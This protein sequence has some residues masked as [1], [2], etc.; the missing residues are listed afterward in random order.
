MQVSGYRFR[1]NHALG[2]VMFAIATM[3]CE[4]PAEDDAR[5]DDTS[6]VK[7]V[8]LP[9]VGGC[10]NVGEADP[11]TN[12]LRLTIQGGTP[13][14][15]TDVQGPNVALAPFASAAIAL[16]DGASWVLR[17]ADPMPWISFPGAAPDTIYE[18]FGYWS[19]AD[20]QLEL[21]PRSPSSG[22]GAQDGV[23]VKWDDPT[24]RYLGAVATTSG[25]TFADTR[26]KRLVWNQDNKVPRPITGIESAGAWYITG[27]NA[28]RE[29]NNGASS[30]VQVLVGNHHSSRAY[31]SVQAVGMGIV[32]SPTNGTG[33]IGTGIGINSSSANSA[34]VVEI[35]K[36]TT[37][38]YGNVSAAY[39]G[40]LTY[41]LHSIRWLEIG[42]SGITF[43]VLGTVTSP[44]F[45]KYGLNGY[46]TM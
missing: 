14:P 9:V 26:N 33:F 45:G 13:V 29:V 34:Q 42:Q 28:W 21:I 20:V 36:A 12:G 41:G 4:Q 38:T 24:R 46:V 44:P 16:F 15:D 40:Y 11:T 3:A 7:T 35:G 39:E 8:D 10:C 25:G 1:T 2:L 43:Y 6:E 30:R 18:V 19:G 27:T 37:T 22:I 31:V 5:S 32:N 17:I 23:A